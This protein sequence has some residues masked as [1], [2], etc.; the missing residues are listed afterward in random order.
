MPSLTQADDED[1]KL[2]KS[3]ESPRGDIIVEH[4]ENYKADDYHFREIW[5]VS[6]DDPKQGFLLY[7]HGRSAEVIFSPDENW[8]IIN[9]Y[10]G[11][12]ASDVLL[13]Q[14]RNTL[15]YTEVKKAD[16]FG[17]AWIHLPY[18]DISPLCRL[19]NHKPFF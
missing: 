4:Y 9:D 16:V 17:K 19:L 6:K 3:E 13:F 11:S 1:L 7:S 2:N 8:L 5:L 12:N 14:K 10:L 15:K 18:R